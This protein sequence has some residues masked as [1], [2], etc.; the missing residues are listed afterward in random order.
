LIVV[1]V[2]AISLSACSPDWLINPNGGAG[3]K[4]T[5]SAAVVGEG[6]FRLALDGVSVSGA[7]DAAPNGTPVRAQLVTHDL[8]DAI[9]G[10]ADPVGTGLDITLGDGIQPA[11]PLTIRFAPDVVAGWG[12]AAD[13]ASDLTPVVFTSKADGPG[14]ELADARLLPDGSVVVT[15]DHLSWVQPALASIS[16]FS[17]WLGEQV[18]TFMQVRSERPDCVGQ[19]VEELGWEF[20]AIP[21]QLF[22]PCVRE[23]AGGLEVTFTNNSPEVWLVESDQAT[24]GLPITLSITGATVAA[25]ARQGIDQTTTAPLI[26]PDGAVR[27]VANGQADEIVFHASL[28]TWLTIVNASVSALSGFIPAKKLEALGKAQCFLDLVS[29]GVNASQTVADAAYGGL[30]SKVLG[31][32]GTVVG[33]LAGKLISAVTTIPGALTALIDVD[34]RVLSGA[35]G[36][37]ITLS[38]LGDIAPEPTGPAA[39]ATAWPSDRQDG[40]PALLVWLGANMYGFPDWIACDDA[41]TYCLVGYSGQE[42]LLVQMRG[43]VVI[44]TVPDSAADPRQELLALGLPD[45]IVSQIL[46]R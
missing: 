23:T 36:F 8:P 24:P 35:T 28:N 38:K 5:E 45:E 41:R 20:S 43:L 6:G 15:A 46:G 25:T 29:S 7:P 13:S 39:A 37:S 10:F 40:P 33:A 18:L 11:S 31:C 32:V 44:G 1:L 3:A 27:F 16:G 42:H 17:D 19:E 12:S 30:A 22:W 4:R 21:N 34:V 26:P 9:G 2:G 14:V